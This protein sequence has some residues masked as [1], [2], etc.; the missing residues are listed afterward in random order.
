MKM[1][2]IGEAVGVIAAQS[3]GE[4]GTQLTLRTFHIG[5]AA[6][7]IAEQSQVEAKYAGKIALKDIRQVDREDGTA[8]ITSRDG[9]GEAHIVDENGRVRVRLQVPYGAHMFVKEEQAVE[10]GD[11]IYEFDPYNRTIITEKTGKVKWKDI[12]RDESFREAIDDQTG[13]I[14]KIIVDTD[15]S[16]F[17]TVTIQDSKGKVIASYRTPTGAQ[18]QVENG[19]EVAA[20]DVLVTMRRS[21][22]K[23]RDITGGLPRVAELFEARKPHEPAQ[24]AEIEGIVDFGKTIR[25]QQQIF[26]KG[27]EG[28]E[29]EYLIPHGRHLMV[30]SGDRVQAGDRLCEGPKD[31]HDIL[32]V[33]GDQ[34]VQAY[35]VDEIQ[36]VY[37]LQGVKINDKH[38]EVIVRQMMQKVLIDYVGDTNFLEGE[39]VDKIKFYEENARVIAEGG[40][41]ARF[42]PLLLGITRASLTTESFISAASF[43]ETTKVLTEAA[44]SGKVDY[45]LGL[46]ENVIIGHLIPA[47]TGIERYRDLKVILEDGE[48]EEMG[49][50]RAD[51]KAPS[52]IDI[53]NKNA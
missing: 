22:S 51:D 43:Q 13:M 9:V 1:V 34:A 45:L 36:E 52:A 23:S 30:H 17:P 26:V 32:K 53:F 44:V 27:E 39:K 8:M 16:L 21:I 33:S 37:R 49:D 3:I 29:Q 41:P 15:K 12:K 20:G 24:I 6:A 40:E 48:E 7:R 14:Q 4:P 18:L 25:G 35:L 42:Q 10:K 31:P 5:G 11:V 28:E 2:H 19:Q 50:V 38:I 47:G 46:K